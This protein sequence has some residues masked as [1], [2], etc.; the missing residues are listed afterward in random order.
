MKIFQS[1]LVALVCVFTL[2]GADGEKITEKLEEIKSA[3]EAAYFTFSQESYMKIWGDC[4]RI[5]AMAPDN[6][7]AKY[8]AAY[9]AYRLMNGG[10]VN[11]D[12]SVVEKYADA[13]LKYANQISVDDHLKTEAAIIKA[14]IIMMKLAIFPQEAA[15]LSGQVHGLLGEALGREP[16]NPRALLTKGIML[17]NTPE[18]YG[19]SVEKA[20]ELFATAKEKYSPEDESLVNWGHPETMAWLGQAYARLGKMESAKEVYNEALIKYPEFN[21]VKYK[22]LPA[23]DKQ[24]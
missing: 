3:H 9:T 10:L 20:A 18:T 2:Y 4:E 13:G 15:T 5:V 8:F 22:L 14:N 19:G 24:K 12:K 16:E 17:F 7:P 21:W 23:L 11:N 6:E 1:I